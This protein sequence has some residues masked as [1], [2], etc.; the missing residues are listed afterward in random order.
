[1]HLTTRTTQLEPVSPS[2]KSKSRG[3]IQAI[4]KEPIK[5]WQLQVLLLKSS[6]FSIGKHQ[7]LLHNMPFNV[8]K[9]IIQAIQCILQICHMSKKEC[10]PQKTQ[11][12][13]S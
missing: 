4:Q 5:L 12:P 1:M 7:Q 11:K 13:E 8:S 2:G 6:Y 10:M 3:G 9:T